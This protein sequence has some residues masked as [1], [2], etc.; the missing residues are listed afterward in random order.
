M[1]SN[2][3][4]ERVKATFT[5]EL[6]KAKGIISVAAKNL[7]VHFDTIYRWMR[8]DPEFRE[9]VNRVRDTV[10]DYYESKLIHLVEMDNP[11]AIIFVAK[12]RLKH[13]GYGGTAL[14]DFANNSA[15][16]NVIKIAENL[17]PDEAAVLERY[18]QQRIDQHM[19]KYLIKEC[20]N[21]VK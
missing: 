3:Y 5:D 7:D 20:S 12:T 4:Y 18:V 9:S 15:S 10:D 21:E 14:V 17:T 8:E 11:A 6:R 2:E 13:R 19:S 1:H 16:E